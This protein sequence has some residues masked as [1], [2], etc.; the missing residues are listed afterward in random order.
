MGV[1]T[2]IE[3]WLL[4]AIC[5]LGLVGWVGCGSTDGDGDGG[6]GGG[7]AFA[8]ED[9]EQWAVR[10]GGE[11]GTVSSGA[12]FD[13]TLEGANAHRMQFL[14]GDPGLLMEVR[15]DAQAGQ[16]GSFETWHARMTWEGTTYF[17]G[18]SARDREGETLGSPLQVSIDTYEVIEDGTK[19]H[20]T[21]TISGDFMHKGSGPDELQGA[22]TDP[23]AVELKFDAVK[24]R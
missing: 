8:L 11:S 22:I 20:V 5:V 13:G 21:G 12:Q 1:S 9:D 7:D 19:W 6:G 10:V 4:V 14:G 18:T 24:E 15:F 17:T 3:R 16:A 2:R 23:V